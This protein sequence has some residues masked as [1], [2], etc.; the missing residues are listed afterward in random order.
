MEFYLIPS[1]VE[2]EAGGRT[3]KHSAPAQKAFYEL[4]TNENQLHG[5]E[6]FLRS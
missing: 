6:S 2:V 5:A 3:K 1:S 4:C